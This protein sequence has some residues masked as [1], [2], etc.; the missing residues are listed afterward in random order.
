[1]EKMNKNID[2]V[3]KIDKQIKEEE[4]SKTVTKEKITTINNVQLNEN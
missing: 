3:F 1:M 2:I 4:W